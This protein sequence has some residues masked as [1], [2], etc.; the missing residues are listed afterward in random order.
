MIQVRRIIQAHPAE[1]ERYYLCILLNNIAGARSFKELRTVKD[2]EYHTF[3]EAAEAQEL[4]DGDNSWDHAL[5][6]EIIWAMPPSIRRLFA[7]ILV[8]GEPSNV[9]GLWD[10]HLEAM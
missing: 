7:T 9:H 10:K 4:I 6:E 2:V 8:F 5:K 3:H 1:G